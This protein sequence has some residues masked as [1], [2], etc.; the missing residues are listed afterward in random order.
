MKQIENSIVL[1]YGVWITN[2][3]SHQEKI[4]LKEDAYL[5]ISNNSE[6][7]LK[8]TLPGFCLQAPTW[9]HM[10]SLQST[11]QFTRKEVSL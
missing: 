9:A 7:A 11:G 1:R 6:I 4:T 10:M 5:T 2:P 3:P 8:A